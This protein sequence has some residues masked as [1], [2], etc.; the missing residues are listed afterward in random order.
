MPNEHL[1]SIL[2][3]PADKLARASKV[4]LKIVPDLEG[5]YLHFAREIADEIKA[6]NGTG[7]LTRL[8]LPVGPIGQYPL[9]MQICNREGISW[10]N[11][12]TFNMDDY[13]D[14]QG[15]PLPL[16]HPLSFEGYMRREV[17]D[18]LN[19]ELRIPEE[20]IH[21]PDPL[22]LDEISRQIDGVGG[23]DTCYGGVGIHGH[24]AFNEPPISRYYKLTA[25]EFRAS[26][27]RIVPLAPETIVMNSIRATGGNPAGLPPMA[28]TLGMKDILASRRLRLY[29]QGGTWQRTILR[30]ALLGEEDI[31]YPVTL[32]QGHRDYAIITDENTAQ[33]PV[34]SIA[35]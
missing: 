6:N 29:C 23:I 22:N 20:Q 3:I 25:D 32:A 2:T 34:S 35:A 21:F 18:K 15:R 24:I 8:I 28:V 33:T 13:L 5:L 19:P 11:V 16:E 26:L 9:L 7:T 1:E 31:D 4:S 10:K 14:W 12:H 17:F 27:T 30:I